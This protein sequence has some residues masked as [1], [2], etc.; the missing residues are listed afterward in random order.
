MWA[1]PQ[2]KSTPGAFDLFH[3]FSVHYREA[4]AED[5]TLASNSTK[6]EARGKKEKW[7]RRISFRNWR[8]QLDS[9]DAPTQYQNHI[10][11]QLQTSSRA[12]ADTLEQ[13]LI[14]AAQNTDGAIIKRYVFI[15]P[16][17]WNIYEHFGNRQQ[18]HACEKCGV[19][20]FG[21]FSRSFLAAKRSKVLRAARL[22]MV[23]KCCHGNMEDPVAKKCHGNMEDP[24]AKKWGANTPHQT[25][26][27]E[28]TGGIGNIVRLLLRQ[29][30]C[31]KFIMVLHG[32]AAVLCGEWSLLAK[33]V[34]F[35]LLLIAA[36][37]S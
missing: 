16:C 4:L 5:T 25:T 12:S 7:K 31:G 30:C 11:Q 2:Q 23:R 9:D 8:P 3:P 22:K 32:L 10:R 13:I 21:I 17:D 1:W 15:H 35:E 6:T 29:T 27:T 37:I 19:C 18:I 33:N 26:T 34:G 24:A 28:H 14:Q 36:Y 20:K